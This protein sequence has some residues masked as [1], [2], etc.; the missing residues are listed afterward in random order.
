MKERWDSARGGTGRARAHKKSNGQES[1]A[2]ANGDLCAAHRDPHAPLRAHFC[3]FSISVIYTNCTPWRE[4]KK[5]EG[6]TNRVQTNACTHNSCTK[7]KIKLHNYSF[8]ITVEGNEG[9]ERFERGH[10]KRKNNRLF[11]PSGVWSFIN[12][13]TAS[14]TFVD[15]FLFDI[16]I[17]NAQNGVM[18]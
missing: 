5:T 11:V 17:N 13:I 9:L 12:G 1:T 3:F 15:S 10:C 6:A 8:S 14:Y 18:M 4:G 7:M 16:T 2:A